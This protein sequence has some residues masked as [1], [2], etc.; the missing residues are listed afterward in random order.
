MNFQFVAS[1]QLLDILIRY[2]R[3]SLWVMSAFPVTLMPFSL[4]CAFMKVLTPLLF[5]FAVLYDLVTTVR[6]R[7]YDTGI[8]PCAKFELPVVSVGNLSVGG[9]GKTPMIEYLIRLFAAQCHVAT[10]SRGYGRKTKGVK[11]AG[12][13]DSASTIG[14]EPLQFYR[15]FK[16]KAVVA[17]GEERAFAIPHILDRHPDVGIIL[18]D[19]AFQHRRVKPSFQ[20]LLT[21][22][23][24]LF[25]SDFLLPA[26]RLRESR[27]GASRA[28]VIVVTKCP[29]KVTDDEMMEIERCIRR[30]NKKAVFFTKISYG[31]ILPVSGLS[32]YKPDKVILV[33]GIANPAPMQ[34]Y[35]RSNFSLIKH[36]S[37]PDHHVYS[38]NELENI[39]KAASLAGASVVTTE[40]D[41]GK[42][43]N[44]IFQ[45]AS[46]SLHYL[47][48]EV[49]FIKDGKEFDEMVLNAVK[50]YVK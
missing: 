11:I 28:D 9:T 14:D 1:A 22:F 21:D 6:N 12:E 37:Y 31:N 23:N 16:D 4:F 3:V 36:F 25:F 24:N 29:A 5:P 20:I 35:I 38:K 30:Y 15:K 46:I 41:V 45:N 13:D 10:L 40:K 48:I 18:L 44:R 26:G 49:E 39:C 27:T 7:L 42:M 47:P 33:T 34:D 19:D 32:P 43:D 17:V 50:T 8:R 2:L